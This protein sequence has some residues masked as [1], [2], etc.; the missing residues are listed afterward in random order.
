[1]AHIGTRLVLNEKTKNNEVM[2]T[3]PFNICPTCAHI[4][5]CVLTEMKEK[6]WS[7]SEY[8]DA[9]PEHKTIEKPKPERQ[10]ELA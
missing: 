1:M 5:T 2:T 6:V 9:Q 8:D 7:C 4:H 3:N 10:L